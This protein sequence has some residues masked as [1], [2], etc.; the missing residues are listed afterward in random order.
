MPTLVLSHQPQGEELYAQKSAHFSLLKNAKREE[1]ERRR[2]P[3]EERAYHHTKDLKKIG[4]MYCV[5][6]PREE[7]FARKN[8][9]R[10]PRER[11]PHAHS[12]VF[13]SGTSEKRGVA[14]ELWRTLAIPGELWRTRGFVRVRRQGVRRG[15]WMVFPRPSTLLAGFIFRKAEA[16]H[17]SKK[18]PYPFDCGLPIFSWEGRRGEVERGYRIHRISSSV[19]LQLPVSEKIS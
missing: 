14:R 11:Q 13:P 1:G 8:G 18:A 16:E 5:I 9:G 3:K 17:S 6:K 12:L 7:H 4:W 15:V 19:D 2:P 10:Q